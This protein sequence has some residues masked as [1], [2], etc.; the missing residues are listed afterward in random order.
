MLERTGRIRVSKKSVL[1]VSSGLRVSPGRRQDGQGG[2][3]DNRPQT[4]ETSENAGSWTGKPGGVGETIAS[5]NP[6][7]L[8]SRGGDEAS[9]NVQ[10]WHRIGDA[11]GIRRRLSGRRDRPGD[12]AGCCRAGSCRGSGWFDRPMR[13]AQLTLVENDPD[14]YDL[15]FWLDYFRRTHADAACLS[16]GGVRR[17]LPDQGSRCTTAASGWAT[18][19]RSASWSHGCRKLGMDVIART[20]P[21]A[22]HQDVYDAHPDWIAVDAEGQQRR[23]WAMPELWVTCALGPYNF[24]FMTEVT[25]EIVDALHGGRHL[26]QPLDRQR[27]CAT[28]STASATSAPPPAS[29]CRARTTR[30]DPARRAY[31]AWRREAAVRAVAAL[32]RRDPRGQSGRALHPQLRRR[33]L[34]ELDMKTIGELRRH[35]VRRPPGAQRADAALGQRQERQGVPRHAWA[36]KPIGGIFSVGV[37][38]PYRWKDSVQSEAEIRAVGRRR[39]RQRLA[40]LVHQVR[41]HALRPALADGAS[42]ICTTGT[43][44]TSGICAT[45]VRWRASALVYSQQ[46]C[47]LLRR[48]ARRREGRRPHARLSTTR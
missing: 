41:R 26:P 40:A 48:R 10:Q 27:A 35:P 1:R 30:S 17:L 6:L 11:A 44:G 20:D 5:R 47:H 39:H 37:E 46:T 18:A 22:A 36:R 24:E 31:I 42:R 32:G 43:I 12:R 23:H 16:A 33:A 19:T 34:S 29:T 13:W 38:E 45:S 7:E 14:R 8:W 28:A 21:H 15:A 4:H 9:T 25:R 3:E 2:A